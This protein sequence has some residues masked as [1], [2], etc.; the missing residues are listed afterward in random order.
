MSSTYG[1][2]R[3]ARDKVSIFQPHKTALLAELH[4]NKD[5][6]QSQTF[7]IQKLIERPLLFKNRKFD[8][9][10]WV[11]ISAWDTKVYLYKEG[12]VRTSSKVYTDYDPKLSNSE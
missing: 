9:R 12:Y 1:I 6:F 4:C 7:V 2:G 10:V 5:K 11:L 8:I 3:G